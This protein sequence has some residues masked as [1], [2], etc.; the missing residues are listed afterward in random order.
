MCDRGFVSVNGE[1]KRV[2]GT[3]NL[4]SGASNGSSNTFITSS[5]PNTIHIQQSKL[6]QQQQPVVLGLVAQQQQIIHTTH[7][8]QL[9][10]N[11][12][13]SNNGTIATVTQPKQ[14]YHIKPVQQ[15]H[16]EGLGSSS[17]VVSAST[18]DEHDL[19]TNTSVVV[20]ESSASPEPPFKRARSDVP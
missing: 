16:L 20:T 13:S 10:N 2:V 4:S 11:N 9:N 3:A 6:Q 7:S 12:I 15:Q 18:Y 5:S 14:H 1:L 8:S 19:V 17:V